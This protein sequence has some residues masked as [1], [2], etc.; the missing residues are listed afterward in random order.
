MSSK[1]AM[2]KAQKQAFAM[3]RS[4]ISYNKID[5]KKFSLKK[6]KKKLIKLK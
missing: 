5:L 6:N 3:H 1:R 4:N 2:K